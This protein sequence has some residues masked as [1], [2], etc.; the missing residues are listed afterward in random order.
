MILYFHKKITLLLQ[1]VAH[2]VGHNLGMKHDF[3]EKHGGQSS[4]CNQ[5]NHI[6]AYGSSKEKWSTCSKADFEAH[7]LQVQS[8]W[9]M[10]GKCNLLFTAINA[11]SIQYTSD[12][13]VSYN[14]FLL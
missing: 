10:E 1:L 6:M 11:A 9:C 3:D 5:D 4:S 7:Y 14:M 12:Y 8:N 13:K 2:E